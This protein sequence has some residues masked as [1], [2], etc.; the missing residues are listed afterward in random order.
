MSETLDLFTPNP[1]EAVLQSLLRAYQLRARVTDRFEACGHW[2]EPAPEAPFAW[3]H[4]VEQGICHIR[5]AS[6]PEPL[7]M[8]PGDLVVFPGGAAHHLCSAP[9]PQEEHPDA[10][11]VMLC[12]EFHFD[13]PAAAS[14][15][16]ALPTAITV[17]ADADQ[18]RLAALAGLLRGEAEAQAFGSRAVLDKLSDALFVIALRDHLRQSPPQQGLLAALTD[19][20]LSVALAAIHQQPGS[21]WSVQVLADLALQSRAAFAQ[22][23]TELLGEP[24]MRYLL[25]WRM[26]VALLRLREGR[27]S[28]AQV[29][30]ELGFETEA[31]FRRAFKRIHGFGPGTARREGRHESPHKP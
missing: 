1:G 8:A 5:S 26:T 28:V 4:V 13:G 20:R 30:G 18:G 14:L 12:G 6:L 2:N 10:R 31:A 23:F 25:R 7:R 16:R 27:S 9:T 29:A 21:D 3:F 24:P 17:R 19:P 22:R 11:V 15:M